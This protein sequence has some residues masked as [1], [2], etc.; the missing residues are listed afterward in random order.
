MF[1]LFLEIHGNSP[2]VYV[3][4]SAKVISIILLSM[5]LYII[6]FKNYPVLPSKFYAIFSAIF[7]QHY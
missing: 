6:L 4:G 3:P 1:R 5:V 7:S 2:S